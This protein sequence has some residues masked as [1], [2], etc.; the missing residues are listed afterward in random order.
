MVTEETVASLPLG[1][2]AEVAEEAEEEAA[3]AL[4]EE[5]EAEEARLMPWKPGTQPSLE[6]TIPGRPMP[7]SPMSRR[8]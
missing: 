7:S 6:P 8:I 2:E 4:A 5:E 3:E 1:E